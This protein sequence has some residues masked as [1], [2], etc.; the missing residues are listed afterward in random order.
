MSGLL[1]P[2]NLPGLT[3]DVVRSYKWRTAYQ[4]ALSGKQSTLQL[5]AY[6]L[7]HFELNYELLRDNVTPSDLR[8]LVGLHNQVAGR[9][10]TFLFTDPDFNT[11]SSQL[12][13]TG[14]GASQS[15]Q[16]AASFQNSGGPGA[17]ELIQNLNGAPSLKLTD[18]EVTN[19]ALTTSGQFTNLLTGSGAVASTWNSIGA[20]TLSANADT[21]P[22]GTADAA[23]FSVTTGACYL[24][25]PNF[26]PV[27]VGQTYTFGVWLRV[28]SGTA[29]IN[30]AVNGNASTLVVNTVTV[31]TTWQ[32]FTATF[33]VPTGT[34][35]CGPYVGAPSYSSA[36]S[37]DIFGPTLTTGSSVSK[38]IKTAPNLIGVNNFTGWSATGSGSNTLTANADTGPNGGTIAARWA[39]S[40]TAGPKYLNAINSAAVNGAA[41]YTFGIWVK[42]TSG[43]TINLNGNDSNGGIGGGSGVTATGSWQW[44]QATFTTSATATS[45]TPYLS[46]SAVSVNVD[47]AYP[48]MVQAGEMGVG[49]PGYAIGPTG[50]VTTDWIPWPNDQLLWSGS[51]YYRCRFD[52]DEI[53]WTKFMNQWWS[54]KKVAFTSVTL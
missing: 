3:L 29:S 4:E 49:I 42:A 38:T 19:L 11:V 12:F 35:G 47:L 8:A 31:T 28:P 13:G 25:Y 51:F 26:V 45:I 2:S 48:Q 34:Y 44:L 6:P 37:F 40:A 17:L 53:D 9:W 52:D 15:F 7:V 14:N 23:S 5:R 43:T 41:N 32:L 24:D 27:T 30:V 16:L 20:G 36:A 50:I 39:L 22:D 18:W 46:T 54:A 33:T 10:D 21:S 1:Y